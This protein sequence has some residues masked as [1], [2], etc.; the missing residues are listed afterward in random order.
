MRF[1][2]SRYECLVYHDPLYCRAYFRESSFSVSRTLQELMRLK[3]PSLYVP[4][5]DKTTIYCF[6]ESIRDERYYM[7]NTKDYNAI[8][9]QDGSSKL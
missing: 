5:A 8:T 2:F 7:T 1:A 6:N 4:N 9:L 3:D